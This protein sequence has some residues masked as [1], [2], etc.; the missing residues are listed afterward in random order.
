MKSLDRL[1]IARK[2]ILQTPFA[3]SLRMQAEVAAEGMVVISMAYDKNLA[4]DIVNGLL[5]GGAIAALID[6]SAGLSFLLHPTNPV[7]V[8]TLDLRIDTLRPPMPRQKVTATAVC[9]HVA[10]SVGFVRVSATDQDI[11][12]PIA[13]AVGTFSFRLID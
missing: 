11:N 13:T 8:A 6:M 3:E 2:F 7:D 9:Y 12:N 4:D 5:H 1:T 10:G